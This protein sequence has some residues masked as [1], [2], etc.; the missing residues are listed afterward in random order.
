[1]VSNTYKDTGFVC[2]AEGEH[3]M[4][5]HG[6][7]SKRVLARSDYRIWGLVRSGRGSEEVGICFRLQMWSESGDSSMGILWMAWCPV[8]R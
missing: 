1:M 8:L 3:T 5:N 7:L 6:C 4:G 2:Y